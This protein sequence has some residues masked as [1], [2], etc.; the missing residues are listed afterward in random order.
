VLNYC[1]EIIV[2]GESVLGFQID[3]TDSKSTSDN[4]TNFLSYDALTFQIE[5]VSA[6]RHM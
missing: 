6:D 3:G 5:G 2:F 1:F 4:L